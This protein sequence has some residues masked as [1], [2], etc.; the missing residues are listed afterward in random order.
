MERTTNDSDYILSCQW[1]NH[2]PRGQGISWELQ[3]EV[4]KAMS[5]MSWD[6]IFEKCNC[7]P[8]GTCSICGE[9]GWALTE[10]G[11]RFY[12][13]LAE[14][15][16]VSEKQEK[17]IRSWKRAWQRYLGDALNISINP[18]WWKKDEDET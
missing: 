14:A 11:K 4:S 17:E 16:R 9:T 12:E 2:G 13:K 8:D 10:H 15:L 5:F 3:A 1:W 18:C 6:N 7:D